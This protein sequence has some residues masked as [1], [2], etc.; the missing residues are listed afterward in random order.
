MMM[1]S[2]MEVISMKMDAAVAT[3]ATIYGILEAKY[4]VVGCDV[5]SVC[6]ACV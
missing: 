5:G 4:V 6:V 2:F 3:S 1:T